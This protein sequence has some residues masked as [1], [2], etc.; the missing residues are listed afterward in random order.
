MT[1]LKPRQ[2]QIIAWSLSVLVVVLA[3]TAWVQG[4]GGRFADLTFYQVFPV[5]GLIAFSLMWSHYI[6]AVLRLYFKIERGVLAKYF[7]FTS[8]AVLA[9]ILLHPGLLAWQAYRDGN[10]LP[11]GSEVRYVS[12]MLGLYVVLGI[13]S[14]TVFLTYELRRKFGSRPWWKYVAY[15]SDTAMLLIVIH[16]LKLGGNLQAGWFRAVWYFY[17]VTLLGALGYIYYLKFQPQAKQKS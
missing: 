1:T 2:L 9:S 14:Y 10:G 4:F 3:L 5:F 15:A 12:P 11:P 17:G 7:E 6:A 13:I 8:L 16:S